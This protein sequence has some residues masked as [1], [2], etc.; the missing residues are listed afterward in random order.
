MDRS[1]RFLARSGGGNPARAAALALSTHRPSIRPCMSAPILWLPDGLSPD[2]RARRAVF[3]ALQAEPD[4]ARDYALKGGL[5]LQRV[6]GSPRVSH[7][8]DLNHVEPHPNKV[9]EAYTEKL[10]DVADRLAAGVAEAAEASGLTEARVEVEKWSRVLP[11][12]FLLVHYRTA[13]SPEEE[14]TVEVQVTLCERVCE[15]IPARIDGVPVLASGLN[16]LVADKLK[17][18]LQ[19]PHRHEARHADVYDLWFALAQAPIRAEPAQVRAA[20]DTKL[21]IWPELPPLTADVFREMAV[22]TFA[23]QGYKKIKTEQPDLP[24][25]PFDVVWAEILAFVDDM[26]ERSE[27]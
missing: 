17:V 23:E 1:A 5:V 15:P 3:S 26:M 8:I 11:T 27:D 7:D 13:E 4:L 6:Y 18:L 21:Q 25:A 19:Q 20:L 14:R 12:V 9:S 16:D 2:D 22:E 10:Q 24:F